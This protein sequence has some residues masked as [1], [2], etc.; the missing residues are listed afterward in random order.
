MRKF[1]YTAI[2]CI[3]LY[4]PQ[5]TDNSGCL[6]GQGKTGVADRPN[7]IFIMTDDH[8]KQ[9]MNRIPIGKNLSYNNKFF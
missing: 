7:I 5:F 9:A 2:I 3:I 1:S 4:Q 6:L 8:T